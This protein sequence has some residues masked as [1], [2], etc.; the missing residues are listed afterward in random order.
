MLKKTLEN[1]LHCKEIQPVHPGWKSVLNLHWKDW[2][3]SWN[4]NTLATWCEELTHRKRLWCWER[5]KAGGEG[6]DRGW[7]GHEFKPAL[8]VGDGQ[9]SLV[10]YSP[11]GRR[12]SDMTEWLNWTELNGTLKCVAVEEEVKSL[13]LGFVRGQIVYRAQWRFA[14][15]LYWVWFTSLWAVGRDKSKVFVLLPVGS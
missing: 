1:P 10:C 11:W 12:E 9:R 8:G 7:D 6:D 5:L 14:H 3:W 2:C 4:S 15:Y 13:A